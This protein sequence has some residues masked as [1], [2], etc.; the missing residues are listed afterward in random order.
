MPIIQQ[1]NGYGK[2]PSV[3]NHYYTPQEWNNI[4]S[5]LPAKVE[6]IRQNLQEQYYPPIQ[7]GYV[8]WDPGDWPRQFADRAAE[9]RRM[10]RIDFFMSMVS[11]GFNDTGVWG[12]GDGPRVSR[13]YGSDV[14]QSTSK[15][16]LQHDPEL[17]QL[18]TW[19]DF[20]EGTCFE[21]TVQNG[22]RFLTQLGEWWHSQTGKEV[23]LSGISAAF[24]RYK[25]ECSATEHAEIP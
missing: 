17:V 5:R 7:A 4:F 22:A 1:F 6:Y 23:Q 11:P 18:V 3:G 13:Q 12:W 15:M 8:W 2:D 25:Q 21:P 20:N 9:L 24:D 10:G 16:A 14:V 19:N